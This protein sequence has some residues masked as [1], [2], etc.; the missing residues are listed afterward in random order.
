MDLPLENSSRVSIAN[1]NMS[2][3]AA[4]AAIESFKF[5]AADS[6]RQIQFAITKWWSSVAGAAIL[7]SFDV[8]AL[9]VC[10]ALGYSL[11]PRLALGH[12]VTA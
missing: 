1:S 4:W 11:W 7:A 10:A 9:T 2:H 8:G 5:G 3:A 12:P 6:E